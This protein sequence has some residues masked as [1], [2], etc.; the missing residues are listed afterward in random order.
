LQDNI[1]LNDQPETKMTKLIK[2]IEIIKDTEA[3][4]FDL[5]NSYTLITLNPL[6]IKQYYEPTNNQISKLN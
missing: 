3:T 5:K 4:F 6:I 1:K 2:T